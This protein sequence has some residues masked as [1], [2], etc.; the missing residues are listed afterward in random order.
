MSVRRE[1]PLRTIAFMALECTK[2]TIG[3]CAI[4]KSRRVRV[5]EVKAFLKR[6]DVLW[7]VACM[8]AKRGDNAVLT[9]NPG[10][11][12]TCPFFEIHSACGIRYK[13]MIPTDPPMV[14]TYADFS[15][16]I[17]IPRCIPISAFK[18][19]TDITDAALHWAKR[20]YG[21]AKLSFWDAMV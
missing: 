21:W 2:D 7:D 8:L 4:V 9:L 13:T 1:N 10:D 20:R 5:S 11:D 19:K 15:R 14:V 12:D 16:K 18:A 17:V 3:E 6:V